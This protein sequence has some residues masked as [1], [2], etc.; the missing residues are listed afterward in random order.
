MISA[1]KN[2]LK[3]VN[4]AQKIWSLLNGV[5]CIYKPRGLTVN[6]TRMTLMSNICRGKQEIYLKC[7]QSISLAYYNY[8]SKWIKS[9]GA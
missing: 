1:T 7:L 5:I 2:T 8:R 3:L 9:K 4:D 6:Q